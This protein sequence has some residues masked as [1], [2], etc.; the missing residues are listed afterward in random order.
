M[1]DPVVIQTLCIHA[2]RIIAW[3]CVL[4]GLREASEKCQE[5]IPP[6]EVRKHFYMA[7]FCFLAIR[8][9]N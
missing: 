4:H 5:Y 2:V 8:F 7:W 6:F 1:V 3:D 9:M